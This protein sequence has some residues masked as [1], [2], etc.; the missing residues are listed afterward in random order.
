MASE[1][2]N[3][4]DSR[5]P[6]FLA[7]MGD[8]DKWRMTYRGGD[9]YRERYLRRFDTRED[10]NDFA[11]RKSMTPIPTFAKSAINDIRNAI[12]Q[13]LSDVIRKDGSDAYQQAIDGENMGVDNR[14]SSMNYFLGNKCL[15][16]LLV[17]GRVG[18][19][20]DAPEIGSLTTLA[21]SRKTRPY[22]YS[23][24]VEDILNYNCAKPEEP[25]EFQSL[26]LRD[27]VMQY[28]ADTWLPLHSVQRYRL[29]YISPMTGKVNIQFY[30]LDGNLIDRDGNPSGPI[31]LQIE[32]IPFVLFDIGDSLIK[33]V[34]DHQIALLNLGSSDVNYALKSNF[35]FYTEQRD[36]RAVGSH[37]KRVAS[38][39][40]ATQGG[41]GAAD[42]VMK[43]GT[44]Q[45][46]YYD[47]SVERPGFIAPP[48]A[49]LEASMK[50]QDKL[51]GDIRKLVNL[52]IVNLGSRV[53]A[54]SKKVDNEGLDA[55]LSYI[56]LVMEGGER[57][58]TD[59]WSA[60]EER[61]PSR[62]Q[63]ATIKYPDKYSL[64]TD[65]DRIEEA[66]KLG[67]LIHTIPS[68]VAKR[69]ISKNITTVLLGQ[70]IKADTLK[71]IHAEIDAAPY[72]TSDP[73]TIIEAKEA[74]L[75]GEQTASIALGFDDD[76]H[77]VARKDHI[78]RAT[79]IAKAQGIAR[80]AGDPA[81]RGVSDLSANGNA[82][83]EEKEATR[84][85]DLNSTTKKPVRGEGRATAEE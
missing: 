80:G 33:D 26:L 50:L 13:R 75:V 5:H 32:R 81:S 72:T 4:I 85:T 58:I 48:S 2:F 56:G 71:K 27:T 31:E 40:T 14:G 61:T 84:N 22:L 52:A 74:G 30:D 37:L 62:R 54:E 3:I 7:Q 78:R 9:E 45:G 1:M 39:G 63:V 42:E 28:D 6:N 38:D 21:E 79:E 43:V 25:S 59:F 10:L 55:G 73:K 29:V 11:D 51:E 12:F 20:V 35:P 65:A 23:Y 82:G 47:T 49:P 18:V 67:K 8:W 68:R 17:M 76:E 44:T 77:L 41:Q 24:A 57:R 83:K 53:S 15:S 19:Y 60:Y 66:D 34:A 16:D 64:K 46:R 36:L 69:E 70:K